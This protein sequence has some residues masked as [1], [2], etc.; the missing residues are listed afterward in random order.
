MPGK[1]PECGKVLHLSDLLVLS[2]KELQRI[3]KKRQADVHK[4]IHSLARRGFGVVTKG[5]WVSML[6]EVGAEVIVAATF[7]AGAAP[8]RFYDEKL[9]DTRIDEKT[10]QHRRRV[11]RRS[12]APMELIQ[13]LRNAGRK[14][15]A[16]WQYVHGRLPPPGAIYTQSR[17]G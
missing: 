15:H 14:R 6:K 5:C 11:I 12:W 17:R 16:L 13:V 9:P 4:G 2:K 3:Q 8:S 7:Y 1:C 10:G